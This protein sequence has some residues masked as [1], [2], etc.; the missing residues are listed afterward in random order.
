VHLELVRALADA[1]QEIGE[2][3][4]RAIV[5]RYLE[6][7]PPR[8]IAARLDEPLKTVKTR[9]NR[10]LG[11]L[12]S[13]LDRRY[14]ERR[15]WALAMA[16]MAQIAP[17]SG[18]ATTS[19]AGVTIVST[20]VKVAIAVLVGVGICLTLVWQSN[21]APGGAHAVRPEA[22]P[23]AYPAEPTTETHAESRGVARAEVPRDESLDVAVDE[24]EEPASASVE[25]ERMRD[26]LFHAVESSL[27]GE[28]DPGLFLDAALLLV[29]LEPGK[30]I[31]E[32]SRVGIRYPLLDT[33]EGVKAELWL[34]ETENREFAN[35]VLGLRVTM[36][37]P[38]DPYVVD[39][40]E[41]KESRYHITVWKDPQ[42]GKVKSFGILTNLRP[43]WP[44]PDGDVAH[45]LL[46]NL[47]TAQPFEPT[48]TLSGYRDRQ[49]SGGWPVPLTLTGGTWPRME[50]IE[51][52]GQGLKK[53]H[54][55]LEE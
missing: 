19:I 10:G 4:R 33:P 35:P 49:P 12:R 54:D 34:S 1:I 22:K 50:D 45:G 18:A 17:G 6:G 7:L 5:L 9:L 53:M 14:G 13:R 30:A 20:G 46:F 15:S 28:M 36:D 25:L 32:P 3:Y 8:E 37:T 21:V 2:P 55:K 51:K 31:P 23:E 52:L 26:S 29:G 27:H 16:P 47:Y 48:A 42:T 44:I 40:L 43:S 38:R 24:P 39:G 41:R 11:L